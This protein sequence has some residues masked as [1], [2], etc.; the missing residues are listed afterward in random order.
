MYNAFT[1]YEWI[2]TGNDGVVAIAWLGENQWLGAVSEWLDTCGEPN[3]D[4][5][6]LAFFGQ[7][8]AEGYEEAC[9]KLMECTDGNVVHE[10]GWFRTHDGG[11]LAL[12]DVA[13]FKYREWKYK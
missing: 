11:A 6:Y 10:V 8:E 5:Q 12:Q 7:V 9:D 1:E 4:K 3:G 2:E 13:G